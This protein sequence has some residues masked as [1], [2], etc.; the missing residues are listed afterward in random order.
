MCNL[1][2]YAKYRRVM[3]YIKILL[4]FILFMQSC[5]S[6][7]KGKEDCACGHGFGHPWHTKLYC[8]L[9]STGTLVSLCNAILI[10]P[11]HALTIG[12]CAIKYGKLFD[13]FSKQSI[14][15]FNFQWKNTVKKRKDSISRWGV[16]VMSS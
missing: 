14:D 13:I 11:W 6:Y 8:T 5:H 16:P 3:A 4:I 10:S 7:K 1:S 9:N 2:L 12:V 15:G